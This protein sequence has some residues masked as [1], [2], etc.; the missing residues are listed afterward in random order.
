MIVKVDLLAAA[1]SLM[2]TRFGASAAIN[3]GLDPTAKL[4]KI[5]LR[6]STAAPTASIHTAEARE[7]GETEQRIYLLSA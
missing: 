5:C 2:K 3:A 6:R 1:P 7:N 4:V